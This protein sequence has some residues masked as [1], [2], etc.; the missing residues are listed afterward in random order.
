MSTSVASSSL[1]QAGQI[2]HPALLVVDSHK[3]E[4]VVTTCHYNHLPQLNTAGIPGLFI[5][6]FWLYLFITWLLLCVI[7][8][9]EV[10]GGVSI[11]VLQQLGGVPTPVPPHE[12]RPLKR[13]PA[14]VHVAPLLQLVGWCPA[15]PTEPH[16]GGQAG[17]AGVP[18]STRLQSSLCVVVA[19]LRKVRESAPGGT[20]PMQHL[21]WNSSFTTVATRH[22]Y[23]WNKIIMIIPTNQT[24]IMTFIYLNLGVW[25]WVLRMALLEAELSQRCTMHSRACSVHVHPISSH[26]CGQSSLGGHWGSQLCRHSSPALHHWAP[27][28]HCLLHFQPSW[29]TLHSHDYLT[30][31]IFL[32]WRIT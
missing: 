15:V 2:L 30:K 6:N 11:A 8:E 28:Y 20:I 3:L 22:N 19:V 4:S 17:R 32:K 23:S 9:R 21:H 10:H 13:G 1:I 12:H 29:C 31:Q 24:K 14:G 16:T 27:L 5:S 7:F 26:I 25:V 18:S